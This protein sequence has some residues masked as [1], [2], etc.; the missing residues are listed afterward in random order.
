V[1]TGYSGL[2]LNWAGE[3]DGDGGEPL[4]VPVMNYESM[5]SPAL[6]QGQQHT[7]PVFNAET[8]AYS[9]DWTGWPLPLPSL[10]GPYPG[11]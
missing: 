2:T 8:P 10:L 9:Y 11:R 6:R 1:A 7:A 4:P 3:P 5:C